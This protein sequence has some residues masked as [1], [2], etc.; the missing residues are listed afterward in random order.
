[1]KKA[2]FIIAQ[3]GFQDFELKIPLE[4]LRDKGID[5]TVAS[6]TTE[7]AKGT[8]GTEIKPD[9]AIDDISTS[10]FDIIILIGGMGAPR[11]GEKKELLELIREFDKQEKLI[12]AICISPTI[13]AKAGV[14][15]GKKATAWKS[16]K[17]VGI[18]QE[19][20]AEFIEEPAVIDGRIITANGP[21]SA[22]LFAEAIYE[23]VI[24]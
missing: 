12:A 17:S 2:V 15:K 24:S 16:E 5:C 23:K 7:T 14:L 11:L 4:F 21:K 18:L 22:G 20:G 13:L 19:G 10:E 6:I 3:E 1:M 9:I 8:F